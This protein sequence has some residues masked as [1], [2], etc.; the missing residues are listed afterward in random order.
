MKHTEIFTSPEHM[1]HAIEFFEATLFAHLH[2]LGHNDDDILAM[3]DKAIKEVDLNDIKPPVH[4]RTP[5]GMVTSN[6][7]LLADD[8]LVTEEQLVGMHHIKHFEEKMKSQSSTI[9]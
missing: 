5:E 2:S 3:L 6:M 1:A 7:H 8:L 4:K 9:H